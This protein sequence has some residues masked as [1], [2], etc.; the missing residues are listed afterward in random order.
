M[1]QAQRTRREHNKGSDMKSKILGLLAVGLLASQAT[2]ASVIYTD[3][4]AWTAA[5]T[6]IT[7]VD[8]EG[9]TNDGSV[10][11]QG[12]ST[13]IGGVTFQ[14][15]IN[16]FVIGANYAE[17]G[18]TFCMGTGACLFGYSGGISGLP[19]PTMSIGF[20]LRGYQEASTTFDIT[21]SNAETYSITVANPAGGFWGVTTAAP[22]TSVLI[23]PRTNYV[24]I[25]NFS[26]GTASVPEPGTLALLGLG[27]AGLGLSRRRK[28]A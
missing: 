22:I 15:D 14:S 13:T 20:D 24:I 11:F 12:P 28:A 2:N 19:G 8:F 21:L 6:S 26:F 3:R 17:S 16:M 25:D 7:N 9:I 1:I 18:E 27:L 23:D 4:A 5:T 10:V